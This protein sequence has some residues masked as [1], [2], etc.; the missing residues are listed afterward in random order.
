MSSSPFMKY[1]SMKRENNSEPLKKKTILFL[2][3]L[4][5]KIAFNPFF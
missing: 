2:M 3:N 5:K 4:F 1:S